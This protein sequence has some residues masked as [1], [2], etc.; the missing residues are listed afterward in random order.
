MKGRIRIL[1]KEPLSD[2]EINMAL[3]FGED[4]PAWRALVQLFEKAKADCIETA[5]DNIQ[6]SNN[7]VVSEICGWD[8]L[9]AFQR[10]LFD[11]RQKGLNAR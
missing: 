8:H 9:D 6:V 1:T 5:A 10:E 11:R 3:A 7:S 4:E 2:S